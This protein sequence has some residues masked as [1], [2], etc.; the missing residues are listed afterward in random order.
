[1]AHITVHNIVK[2]IILDVSPPF[3]LYGTI[4]ISTVI[5][6]HRLKQNNTI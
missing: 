5:N 4:T 2:K 6:K 1:M 3:Q